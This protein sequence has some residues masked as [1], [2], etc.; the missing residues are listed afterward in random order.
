MGLRN[1]EASGAH[2][3]VRLAIAQ[4]YRENF[5]DDTE[6]TAEQRLRVSSR[7][8]E[9]GNAENE[10]FGIEFGYHYGRSPIVAVET[11]AAYPDDSLHYVP[12]TLPGVR[13]PSSFLRD[14]SALFDQLGPW[15]TLIDFGKGNVDGF[16]QAARKAAVPLELLSLQ[17]PELEPIYG[18]M[19]LLVRPDQHIA[20]RGT[21]GAPA[22]AERV[23]SRA[24]GR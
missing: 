7:I 10:S 17:E 5:P 16:V 23:L 4:V 6:P 9:L 1:R 15:F 2:T 19:M 21:S 11:G 18:K 12:T 22:D 3:K 14:G 13:L 20:W 8:A 24:L